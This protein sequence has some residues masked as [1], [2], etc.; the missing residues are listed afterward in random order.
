MLFIKVM[1]N[2]HIT[3]LGDCS[4]KEFALKLTL[5]T[6][7]MYEC[8]DFSKSDKDFFRQFV[9]EE[10]AVLAFA[11]DEELEK[12]TER[13]KNLAMAR[14]VKENNNELTELLKKILAEIEE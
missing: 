10:L 7:A 9:E 3:M 11:T 4:V 14:K 5:I 6:K 1:D 12:E 2:G 8:D 13:I